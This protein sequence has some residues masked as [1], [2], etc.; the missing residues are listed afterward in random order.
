MAPVVAFCAK[1][2]P[3]T[4]STLIASSAATRSL[5]IRTLLVVVVHFSFGLKTGDSALDLL[6]G[7]L[8]SCCVGRVFADLFGSESANVTFCSARRLP[9]MPPLAITAKSL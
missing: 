3:A 7:H 1:A 8:L 4:R 6:G 9:N 2:D 5:F